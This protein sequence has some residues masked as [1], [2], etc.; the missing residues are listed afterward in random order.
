M[1][2]LLDAMLAALARGERVALCSILASSGSAPRGA[3]AKMAVFEDSSTLGTIGGGAVERLSGLRAL[4]AMKSGKNELG[5]YALHP[6]DVNDIGM[7]C[8]GNVT[9]YFQYFDPADENGRAL[10][11]GI[12]ELLR[13]DDDS[14]LVYRMDGGC[15]SAMGTFDE[16]HGLRFTDCITP[17][18]LRPM[19]LSNAFTK[20][21]DPG[22]YIEPLTQAGHAYIFGGGHVGTALAPVLASVGF[23]VVVYD[24]RPDFAKPDHYPSAEQVILGDYL[25]IGTHL[26]LTEN[27]YVCIMTPGH[28]ADREVLL[29]A[30]RSPATYIGCIGS[31]HKIAATNAYLMANGIPEA[32]LSRVH[33]PIGL[34]I[35]GQTPAEIAVSVAA[36]MIRHRALRAGTDKKPSKG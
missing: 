29:Q 5:S 14:W 16:A 27:D 33:A 24:N 2:K 22:Y 21:G 23:R 18:A 34:E 20:K 32:D 35:Y 8:G 13:G 19:L 1:K 11:Q 6:S 30:L 25:D 4:E 7:I 9:V 12:L 36:E 10:L 26:T 15:V 31:R 28:Q 3:G 17:E